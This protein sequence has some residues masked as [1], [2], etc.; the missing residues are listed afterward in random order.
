M[1]KKKYIIWVISIFISSVFAAYQRYSGPTY[2]VKGKVLFQ[3]RY[4]KYKFP[5][6]CTIDE[7]KCLLKFYSEVDGYVLYKRYKV[8]EPYSRIE[9]IKENGQS[10]A[11]L[12]DEFPAAGKIE[13]DVFIN[14]DH[15]TKINNSS[16]ILRFKN[17]VPL[18]ILVPHIIFMFLFMIFSTYIFISNN[19]MTLDKKI[20]YINYIFLII[21]GFIYGPLLQKYAFDQY[22][23]GFPF[24]FDLTDNKTLIIFLFWSY[25]LYKLIKGV[26][27]K[28]AIN[29]SYILTIIVY[30]IPHSLFGSEYRYK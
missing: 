14:S 13:Y 29:I 2:P 26:E 17:N 12:P 27:V 19:I 21:G 24:G 20:F 22:W 6:S 9:F 15:K 18:F 23:T 10:Y 4:V 28:K 5:R 30:L 8:D 11:V 16:I 25:S 1:L 7:K 3:S